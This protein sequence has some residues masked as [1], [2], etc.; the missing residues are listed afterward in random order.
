MT[1]VATVLRSSAINYQERL[2]AETEVSRFL[3]LLI[4]PRTLTELELRAALQL[5]SGP[6]FCL[7][8]LAGL[9]SILSCH[10]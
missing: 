5:V 4:F 1:A 6:S 3:P 7:L 8:V 9:E 2:R 10:S